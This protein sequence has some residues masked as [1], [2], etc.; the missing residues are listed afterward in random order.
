MQNCAYNVNVLYVLIWG[1]AFISRECKIFSIS[2]EIKVR[3]VL[4]ERKTI[5]LFNPSWHLEVQEQG[6]KYVQSQKERP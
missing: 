2:F 4:L 3:T 5:H 1:C 6:M